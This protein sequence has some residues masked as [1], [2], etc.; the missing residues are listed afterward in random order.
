MDGSIFFPVLDKF[1]VMDSIY[2]LDGIYTRGTGTL[3]SSE[4][5]R[6]LWTAWAL[7]VQYFVTVK[8]GLGFNTEAKPL[9]V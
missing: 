7:A 8:K 2:A 9:T 4:L 5:L 1:L 3:V 6:Q